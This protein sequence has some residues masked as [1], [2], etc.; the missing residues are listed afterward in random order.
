MSIPRR[1]PFAKNPRPRLR[2]RN[3][4]QRSLTISPP[5]AL[6]PTAVVS[7]W[8]SFL[9]PTHN[10][11]TPE[12]NLLEDLSKT[13][14]RLVWEMKKGQGYAA[15][16]IVDGRLIIFHRVGDEEVLDCL[17]ATNGNRFWQF[18]YATAYQDR[19]GYCDGPRSSPVIADGRVFAIGAEGKLH[20]L[21]LA[22]GEILW[23]RDLLSGIQVD[24]EF[25]RRGGQPAGGSRQV[26]RERRR[27]RRPM[28]RRVRREDRQT[29]VGSRRCVGAKL[30]DPD[31][32]GHSRQAARPGFRRR[33]KQAAYRRASGDRPRR[34]PCRLHLSPGAGRGGNRST[35]RRR[36]LS[37]TAYSFPNVMARAGLWWI[38]RQ[39]ADARTIWTSES[40][41]THFMSAIP[42]KGYLYGIDGHGP[43]DAFFVCAG[44][45][46]GKEKWRTRPLVG[47]HRHRSRF[48]PAREH[49]HRPLL[50]ADDRRR[51]MP[52]PWRVRSSAVARP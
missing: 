29:G 2:N 22:V 14:P 15:P 35:L 48:S 45:H 24:A 13:P 7:D 25:F 20:C 44:I 33:R 38:S 46:D 37:A 28:C 18:K 27:D 1:R 36:S 43:E 19:Y 16:A 41:G 17:D 52:L 10:A 49:R 4:M 30:C 11:F 42:W 47:G 8:P 23:Q 40:F 9:G 51:T 34:R 26:D 32:G 3:R 31:P 5:T 12:T 21:S 6:A 50:A 39:T